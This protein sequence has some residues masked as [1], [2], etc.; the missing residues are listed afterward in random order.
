MQRRDAM[1]LQSGANSIESNKATCK[2]LELE[3][4]RLKTK[5]ATSTKLLKEYYPLDKDEL[6][7]KTTI[8]TAL[9][10]QVNSDK[11]D[12]VIVLE[13][14]LESLKV[15]IVRGDPKNLFG[16]ISDTAEHDEI[17]NRIKI[18]SK[19][20]ESFFATITRA[21]LGE[22]KEVKP[23][24]EHLLSKGWYLKLPLSGAANQMIKLR[25]I[26]KGRIKRVR[27]WR[28]DFFTVEILVE[29]LDLYIHVLNIFSFLFSLS[30]SHS[31]LFPGKKFR[32]RS[33]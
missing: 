29:L 33:S 22:K 27:K 26:L 4:A 9:D 15:Q 14:Y 19:Q 10:Q 21:F 16:V 18:E 25:E 6:L 13:N 28:I 23:P 1:V 12:S 5:I 30:L 3:V 32:R 7:S 11:L 24:E 20:N 17:L 31:I 2:T 8:H